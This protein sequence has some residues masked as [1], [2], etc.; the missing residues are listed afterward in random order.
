[1]SD[2]TKG[3]DTMSSLTL[4]IPDELMTQIERIGL[5]LQDIV[6]QALERYVQAKSSAFLIPQTRTWQMCGTLKVSEPEP[7]YVCGH[8]EKGQIITDYAEHVDKVLY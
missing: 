6:V 7:E 5:A 2:N 4:E 1:M 3:D 8:D